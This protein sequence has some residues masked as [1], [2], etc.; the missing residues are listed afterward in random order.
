MHHCMLVRQLAAEPVLNTLHGAQVGVVGRV[1]RTRRGGGRAQRRQR[2]WPELLLGRGV[3]AIGQRAGRVLAH[4]LLEQDVGGDPHVAECC[5]LHEEV[6]GELGQDAALLL[7][8]HGVEGAVA[9]GQRGKTLVGKKGLD[10]G[11]PHAFQAG[12]LLG[13]E[14]DAT[15]AASK[16]SD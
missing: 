6:T 11:G 8:W 7:L 3:H 13:G 12:H 10:L 15:D 9:F 4:P 5:R 16:R 14:A 2:G 1:G